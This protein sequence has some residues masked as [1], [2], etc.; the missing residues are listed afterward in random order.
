MPDL[1]FRNPSVRESIKEVAKYW[2]NKGI[3]GFRLDAA[4]HIIE[5]GPGTLQTDT[6]ETIQWWEEFSS[7]VH[8]VDPDALLIGEVWS[9]AEKVAQYYA[10]GKGLDLC[11]DFDGASA[12]LKTGAKGSIVAYQE[13]L[14]KKKNLFAPTT[15]YAPF[16]SNHD[17]IRTMNILKNNFNK[18]K[19]AAMLLLTSPGT[20][21]IYYGE[22]IGMYQTETGRNDN[23]KR[24]IMQWTNGT[25]AGFTQAKK[26]RHQAS[27]YTN[28]YN[29]RAQSY[30]KSSLLNLYRRVGTL[31]SSYPALYS[32]NYEFINN[33]QKIVAFYKG[34]RADKSRI[35]V[36]SNQQEK[37]SVFP[38]PKLNG[39][40][41][42][43]ISD[44]RIKV[45]GK[46]RLGA[47][48]NLLL[49]VED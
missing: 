17:T 44:K 36:L 43:L 2:L 49:L 3:A 14:N 40:Y 25:N 19:T 32:E 41:H 28:P 33:D 8:S 23:A 9:S 11:F 31:R 47:G 18:A 35:L 10:N 24:T 38:L 42:E 22:E 4:K 37:A 46:I 21:F 39:V 20:P 45:N 12:I 13:S 48:D 26:S 1:N 15:F 16:I 27:I 7:Y 30:K 34:S 29:V 6:P 5:N